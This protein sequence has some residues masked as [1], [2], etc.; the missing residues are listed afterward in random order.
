MP[1]IDEGGFVLDYSPPPGT[2][3]TRDRPRGRQVEAIILRARPA[4]TPSPRRTG[5]E[6]GGDLTEPNQGDIFIR[7]KRGA[8]AGRSRR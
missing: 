7:L 1:K 4:S 5:A 3:L 8:A 6:L 2:S